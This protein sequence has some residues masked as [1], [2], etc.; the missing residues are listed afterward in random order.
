MARILSNL[1]KLK[2]AESLRIDAIDRLRK[3]LP[4]YPDRPDLKTDL[5]TV[6]VNHAT[7]LVDKGDTVT[8]GKAFAEAMTLWDEVL[9][10]KPNDAQGRGR[11]PKISRPVR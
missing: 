8:A 1:G 6:L 3:L 11:P 9:R 4:E 7:S 5:A 10:I 2:D